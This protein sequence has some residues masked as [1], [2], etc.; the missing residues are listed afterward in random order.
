MEPIEAIL[1]TKGREVHVV[2]RDATVL[3][4]VGTMCRAHV[5]A[6]LVMDGDQLA[7]IFSERDLMSRVVLAGKDPAKTPVSEVM[8][9][10]VKSI[11]P[12]VSAHEAM[13]LMTNRRVRHLPVAEGRR[14][15][16]LV[17]IGDLVRWTLH[18]REAEIANLQDYVSGRYPG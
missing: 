17:S 1:Q 2:T 14:I 12:D 4:A 3:D 8:T 11:A 6:V 5:G 10:D 13:S 15:V 18:D 7:G 9:R 16:G